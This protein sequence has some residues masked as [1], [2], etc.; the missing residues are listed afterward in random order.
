MKRLTSRVLA[1]LVIG[2]FAAT[3]M[4]S[5]AATRGKRGTDDTPEKGKNKTIAMNQKVDIENNN[6]KIVAID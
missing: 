1:F 5:C 6:L 4:V 2:A 3:S